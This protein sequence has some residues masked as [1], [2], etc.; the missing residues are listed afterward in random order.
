MV[1]DTDVDNNYIGD[2]ISYDDNDD[3]SDNVDKL[4]DED[5]N[6][7]NLAN[8]QARSSRFCMVIYLDNT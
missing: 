2:D 7:N 5:Q 1:V 4:D 3:Y 8:F 6:C